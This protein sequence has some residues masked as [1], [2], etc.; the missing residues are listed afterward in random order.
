VSLAPLAT[1]PRFRHLYLSTY[2]SEPLNDVQVFEIR[3]LDTLHSCRLSFKRNVI[4]NMSKILAT[5]HS[6]Q[7]Q[8]VGFV[9]CDEHVLLLSTLPHFKKLKTTSS[10]LSRI[11]PGIFPCI[12]TL[13]LIMNSTHF[14]TTL[15]EYRH[16][17]ELFIECAEFGVGTMLN[18]MPRLKRLTLE[19]PPSLSWAH[20]S[21]LSSSLESLSLH[22]HR[23]GRKINTRE[24][25]SLLSLKSLRE[26][27]I[28][29]CSFH[30]YVRTS[31]SFAILQPPCDALPHLKN[32][33]VRHE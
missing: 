17:T 25:E 15:G 14:L 29:Q 12:E 33:T 9:D 3:A 28:D 19:M 7:W 18:D 4:E 22:G 26:L 30:P 21:P 2:F 5:P 10:T 20:N 24:L 16:V 32:V 27:I 23:Y 13:H 31:S 1:L 8:D 6:L 11:R